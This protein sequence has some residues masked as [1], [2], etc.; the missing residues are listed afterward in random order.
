MKFKN[1][2]VI[3]FDLDGTLID[4]VPDLADA[5]NHTLRVLG[6]KTFAQEQIRTWVG[7][8]AQILIQRALC[9]NSTID[10]HLDPARSAEALDIFLTFYAQNLCN[11]TTP[12]PDV[13]STLHSLK[14]AKYR[15]AIITNKPFDFVAPILK[16]L[17]IDGL[18]ELI[19]GGDSLEKKKPDPLP[20]LHACE[21]LNIPIGCCLMVGDSKNDIL[22]AKAAGMQ[23]IGVTYGYNYDEP[24]N[25][26]APD[27]VI[28]KFSEILRLLNIKNYEK[29][30]H[31]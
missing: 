19:L 12:Y 14:A 10:E 11:A 3:L 9:G 27:L 5:V 25:S 30:D 31:D 8:G 7:N 24:I 2:E 22:A 28:E 16:G 23:S 17:E 1:K 18:F 21:K 20:L 13:I 6:Q 26:Y 29:A 15:L 4:S